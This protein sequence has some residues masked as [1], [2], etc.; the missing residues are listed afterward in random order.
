MQ[1]HTALRKQNAAAGFTKQTFGTFPRAL[2]TKH[3]LSVLSY[4]FHVLSQSDDGQRKM[5]GPFKRR[6]SLKKQPSLGLVKSSS[7]RRQSSSGLKPIPVQQEVPWDMLD[8]CLLPVIF[9]HA[10]AVII[11]TVLN[12]LHISQ[13]SAFTL[14]IFFTISTIG[15][16][17]FYHNLKVICLHLLIFKT[18]FKVFI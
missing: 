14:F 16:V 4:L 5:S 17:L 18:N 3:Q 10:A 7:L 13:V 9:C 15:A 6:P 12:V 11:S 2:T 1:A 8:R